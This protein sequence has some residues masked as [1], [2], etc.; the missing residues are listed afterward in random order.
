MNYQTPE[1]IGYAKD[2]NDSRIKM[3]RKIN[4]TAERLSKLKK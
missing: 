1:K 3:G 2:Q 4:K